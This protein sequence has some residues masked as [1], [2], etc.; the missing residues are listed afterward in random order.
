MYELVSPDQIFT[1]ISLEGWSSVGAL[2]SCLQEVALESRTKKV[3]SAKWMIHSTGVGV[4]GAAFCGHTIASM[5][6]MPTDSA[7]LFPRPL[8]IPAVDKAPG[9]HEYA[10]SCWGSV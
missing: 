1:S 9:S 2:P 7:S 4:W 6:S 3:P 10:F 8:V 5:T